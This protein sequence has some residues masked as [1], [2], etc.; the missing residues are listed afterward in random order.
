MSNW[1]KLINVG[2]ILNQVKTEILKISV[3]TWFNI[4]HEQL[5][6]PCL[7]GGAINSLFSALVLELNSTNQVKVDYLFK[8]QRKAVCIQCLF[9][10]YHPKLHSIRLQSSAVISEWHQETFVPYN[11]LISP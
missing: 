9:R 2:Q 6:R 4:D 1:L 10:R 7:Q 8:R 11:F 3:F 5:L